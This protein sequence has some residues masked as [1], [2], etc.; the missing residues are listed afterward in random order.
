MKNLVFLLFIPLSFYS[1][2]NI[3]DTTKVVGWMKSGKSSFLINQTAFSNWISGGEN[4]NAGILSLD[5]D[6]NYYKN[7]WSWDTKIIGSF[8]VNKNSDSKFLIKIDDRI[9]IN[10][11]IAKEF[12][13]EFSFSGFLN[14]KT[15]FARGFQYSTNEQGDEIRNEK[16]RFFS[17]AYTQLGAGIYWKESNTLWVN[18]APITARLI[19]VNKKF[20]NDL[21]DGED[22][23]GVPDGQNSRFELG[24]SV[25]AFYEF[26]LVKNIS[27]EQSINLYSDYLHKA[28]NVDLDYIL[29]LNLKINDYLTTTLIVE[30]LYDNNAIRRIQLREVFGLGFVINI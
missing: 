4:S 16:T 9:E 25:S 10:S 21:V 18:F 14:F 29:T 3:V 27:L 12:I 30:A 28:N 20:T 11:V 5:Y 8:G 7:E 19:L 23:F 22:Y 17:P 24:A 6:I 2:E 26:E 1:Q 13:N 15:Q